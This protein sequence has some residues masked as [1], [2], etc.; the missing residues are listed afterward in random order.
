[1]TAQELSIKIE[2]D[3]RNL[4]RFSVTIICV[5]L[6][7]LLASVFRQVRVDERRYIVQQQHNKDINTI[8]AHYVDRWTFL[9]FIQS[10]DALTAEIGAIRNGDAPAV[11]AA[12]DR[13]KEIWMQLIEG[14]HYTTRGND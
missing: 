2:N 14:S 6:V 3:Y 4:K 11:Q 8:K 5:L 13:H 10:I 9:I 1:M 7:F 12:K